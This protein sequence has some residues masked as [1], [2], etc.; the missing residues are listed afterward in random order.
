MSALSAM[1][2]L[3]ASSTLS[4]A[5]IDPKMM[6]LYLINIDDVTLA[7]NKRPLETYLSLF[8]GLLMYDDIS[9]IATYGIKQIQSNVDTSTTVEC[10]HVYNI[11][12][13]YFPIS[14]ILN[15]LI[16]QMNQIVSNL[17]IDNSRTVTAEIIGPTPTPPKKSTPDSWVTLANE[18]IQATKI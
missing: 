3:Y 13:I 11:G 7:V 5:M 4:S 8:A 10:I 9:E 18:T 14:V 12:G 15:D 1:T 2:K 17:E 6:M 16:S